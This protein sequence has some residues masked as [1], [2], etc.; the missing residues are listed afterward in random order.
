MEVIGD[1]I[2]RLVTIE[3]RPRNFIRG[4]IKRLYEA[5]R[6]RAKRPLT[7]LA[8]EKLREEVGAGDQ[9]IIL[10]G[11][12]VPPLIPVGECDGPLGAASLARAITMGLGGSVL[13]LSETECVPL[14]EA[15]F[16]AAELRTV[17]EKIHKEN[18][19]TTHT[20]G[21][22]LSTVEKAQKLTREI[23]DEYNPKAVIAVERAGRNEKGVYHTGFGH[24]M[25][26]WTAKIDHFIDEARKRDILTIGIGDLG[27]EAGMGAIR[28]VVKKVVPN[29]EK[30]KCP[31]GA[32]LA[33]MVETDVTVATA[34]SNLGAYGVTT[35]LSGLLNKFDLLQSVEVE[36]RMIYE[37]INAGG[38]DGVSAFPSL[39][40]DGIAAETYISWVKILRTI[41]EYGLTDV[42][43]RG[44]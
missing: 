24:D 36:R 38:I 27:N 5:A 10:T 4:Y 41:I 31:C 37:C 3:V 6:E 14:I 13:V 8:A 42:V 34:V 29:A 20:R 23:I 18:P 43:L 22:P 35:C 28:D 11:F 33:T 32:G 2:D 44:L 12:I 1:N 30:C 40:V 25:S 26:S 16:R 19:Q 21:F 17:N 7:L 9:V 15:T 39:H